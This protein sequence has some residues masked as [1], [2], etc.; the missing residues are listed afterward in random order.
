MYEKINDLFINLGSVIIPWNE[1]TKIEKSSF[2]RSTGFSL[3]ML[4]SL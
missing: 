1:I 2:S 3:D 4:S